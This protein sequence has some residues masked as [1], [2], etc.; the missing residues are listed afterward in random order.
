[1]KERLRVIDESSGQ[2]GVAVDRE[3]ERVDRLLDALF[4]SGGNALLTP[5]SEF[6]AN[7]R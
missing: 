2:E 7:L 1:M 4:F 5:G 6:D 3:Q